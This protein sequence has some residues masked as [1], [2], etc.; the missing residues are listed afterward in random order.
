MIFIL[1]G[2]SSFWSETPVSEA[3]PAH[4]LS[5][6]F[7]SFLIKIKLSRIESGNMQYFSYTRRRRRHNV[8]VV[9][10]AQARYTLHSHMHL[11]KR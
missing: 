1:S 11:G 4:M 3:V 7:A 6:A 9:T 8:K 5:S 10:L 2:F